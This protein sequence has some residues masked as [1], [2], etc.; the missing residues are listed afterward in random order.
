LG[1]LVLLAILPMLGLLLYSYLEE[2]SLAISNVEGMCS[3]CRVCLCF[4]EELVEGTRQ[5]L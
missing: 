5:L 4:Q 1:L 3:T 2:R